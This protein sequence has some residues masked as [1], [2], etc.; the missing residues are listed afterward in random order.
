MAI[1][2]TNRPVATNRA[3]DAELQPIPFEYGQ[4]RLLPRSHQA[5]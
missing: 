3:F 5:M 4:P 2:Q 1:G